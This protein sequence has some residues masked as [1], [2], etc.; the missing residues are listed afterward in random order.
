MR[1]KHLSRLI[2][3]SSFF[4]TS[5]KP[6]DWPTFGHDP[7]RTGWAYEETILAPDNVSNL[8]LKWKTKVKNEFRV[9][10]ALTVP[11]VASG[12]QTIDG[13]RNVVYVAGSANRVFALDSQTGKQLW[14]R[15]FK[16]FVLPHNSGY[17]GTFLCPNGITATPV[18]DR[19][20]GILYV[21]AADGA[22][23]GL[24]LGSGKIRVGPIQFVAPFAKSFSLNLVDGV[25][26]TTL[27]QGCGGGLS[28]FYAVN[29]RN[30]HEPLLRQLLLSTTDTAGIWGRGG[31]VAGKN[32]RIYGSTADGGFDPIS[33]E[34]SNSVVSG[35]LDDLH[36]V[37]YYTPV[38]WRDINH[39]DLDLGSAS[40]VWFGWRN[41]NLLASGAK[42]GVIY[43]LDADLLGNKD[44]QTPLFVTPRLGNDQRTFEK[45]GIWG[46]LSTYRDE[47]GESWL[48]TPM[49]GPVSESAPKFP[50][51]NGPSPH[52]SIMAFKVMADG[53][54]GKPS[55]QPAWISADFN[56]PDPVIIANGVV[57][58][59]STGEN[60]QQTGS[61]DETRAQ[62]T[63]PAVLYGLDAR[64]GK[65][66]YNSGGAITSWVHFS[67]LAL[68]DGQIYVVDHDS[69]VYCFG[70]KAK[71]SGP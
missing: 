29:V 42:E 12:V 31:P 67:G 46:G 19:S 68:S 2:L 59:L 53:N 60:A 62:N 27:T 5:V 6:A 70:L 50:M 26:Y 7:Q 54:S 10:S 4:S 58:A 41:Y 30:P 64:S 40:P 36:L 47:E 21:I 45:N 8:E 39:R 32:G 63:R 1:M 28:G 16:S 15:D 11:V 13:V 61:T 56:L 65:M 55:L 18:I 9:L 49:W 38:N 22:L 71:P 69:Q 66:L 52:G 20:T 24:D 37:D 43:L 3:I 48:L 14:S 35:S 25:I 44:H 57:F 33:G 51:T 23:Y 34:Y 17:Q